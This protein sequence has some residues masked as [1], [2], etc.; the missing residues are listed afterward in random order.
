LVIGKDLTGLLSLFV[1]FPTLKE[2]GVDKVFELENGNTDPS[3]RNI[4]YLV[5]SGK[6]RLVQA[7]AGMSV[8][9]PFLIPLSGLTRRLHG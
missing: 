6:A 3:Q 9:E 2:Y 4:I 8:A 1:Q 7:V 5:H